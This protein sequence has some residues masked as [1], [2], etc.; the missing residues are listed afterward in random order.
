MRALCNRRPSGFKRAVIR[1]EVFHVSEAAPVQIGLRAGSQS[2]VVVAPPVVQVVPAGISGPT[3]I[4]NLVPFEPCLGQAAYRAV[5]HRVLQDGVWLSRSPR[6]ISLR[7]RVP[8][9]TV[10]A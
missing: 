2:Q 4:G 9:S 5:L 1:L 10:S 8:S 6:P 3:E 7:R